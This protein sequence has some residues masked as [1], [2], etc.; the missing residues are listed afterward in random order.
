MESKIVERTITKFQLNLRSD[1]RAKLETY[2]AQESERIYPGS[3]TMTDV[4]NAAI[5]EYIDRREGREAA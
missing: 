3:L 1:V 4:I 5:S 2:V